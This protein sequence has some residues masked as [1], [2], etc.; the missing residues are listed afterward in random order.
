MWIGRNG[1]TTDFTDD[2]DK[3][4]LGHSL[5]EGRRPF[6]SDEVVPSS[7]RPSVRSATSVFH[8]RALVVVASLRPQ[9]RARSG[10]GSHG[11]DRYH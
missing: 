4:G 9:P 8:T 5:T 1:L 3:K 2:T 7:H 10:P 11:Q 6:Q